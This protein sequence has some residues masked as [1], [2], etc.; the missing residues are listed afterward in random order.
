MKVIDEAHWQERCAQ[1]ETTEEGKEFRRFLID[2]VEEA[3]A[4]IDDGHDT[5]LCNGLPANPV[6][7]DLAIRRALTSVEARHTVRVSTHFLGQMLCVIFLHWQHAEELAEGMTPIEL[8]LV[9][10]SLAIKVAQQEAE[11]GD[12]DDD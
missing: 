1:L 5:Q 8:R 11:A 2:W 6:K 3:E 9:E 12:D 10:D 4:M 7:P